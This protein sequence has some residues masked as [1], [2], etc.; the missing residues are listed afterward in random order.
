[1]ATTLDLIE[2]ALKVIGVTAGDESATAA[3]ADSALD[4]LNLMM[5]GWKLRGADTSHTTLA[6]SDAF[7]LD[8]K[9]HDAVVT[10]L[11]DRLAV[12]FSR[13]RTMQAEADHLWRVLQGTLWTMPTAT[14]DAGLTK[15]PSQYGYGNVRTTSS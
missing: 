11:A 9:Y 2:R 7:P 13:P 14:V 5:A 1:M 8:V 6:L 15:M 4:T 10:I 12:E 3:D